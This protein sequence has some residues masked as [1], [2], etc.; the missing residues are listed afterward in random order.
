MEMGVYLSIILFVLSVLF[1]SCTQKSEEINSDR[2]EFG[3]ITQS[4]NSFI[5]NNQELIKNQLESLD[6]FI[7]KYLDK[8][9]DEY[10]K[11]L[12]VLER[13]PNYYM[14]MVGNIRRYYSLAMEYYKNNQYGN[15][16]E[17]L[18]LASGDIDTFNLLYYQLGLCLMDIGDLETAR[19]FF[20]KSA[21]LKHVNIF[22]DLF[23]TDDNGLKQERYFPYY[24]IACIE[25]LKN[26]IEESFDWLC[27]SIIY[28]YPYINY[29]KND[30]DLNNLFTSEK[31]SF[32]LSQIDEIYNNQAEI[33]KN[34][35][36]GK[37][38]RFSYGDRYEEYHFIDSYHVLIICDSMYQY[39]K[40]IT[41]AEYKIIKRGM[42]LLG[43]IEYINESSNWWELKTEIPYYDFVSNFEEIP[44]TNYDEIK[45]HLRFIG[46][47][48]PPGL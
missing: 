13:E 42:I 22:D 34:A 3:N 12:S 47:D 35:L 6:V 1:V 18:I 29:L 21:K 33:V 41:R 43:N 17:N 37:G 14:E 27:Q 40:D 15:A 30:A 9:S 31:G 26:N 23:T 45:E 5:E 7:D 8:N 48:I 11:L 10:Q 24:N 39:G 38:Y 20:E 4:Q 46:M 28:G 16:I 25:S 44:I 36:I 32:Y 19:M 2:I